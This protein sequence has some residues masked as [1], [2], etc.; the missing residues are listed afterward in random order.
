MD[1]LK[2]IFDKKSALYDLDVIREL[3]GTY[4]AARGGYVAFSKV[5]LQQRCARRGVKEK[6][7]NEQ[8][9]LL[10]KEGLLQRQK[11]KKGAQA[12]YGYQPP[13]DVSHAERS[14]FYP[15][16]L[17]NSNL[18]APEP[19]LMSPTNPGQYPEPRLMSPTNPGQYPEPRLMSPTNPGQYPEPR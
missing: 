8:W 18:P 10:K 19:R 14:L 9:K 12:C 2:N 17:A 11:Y 4:N 3:K 15:P 5:E 16:S 7:F 13:V 1:N 6:D